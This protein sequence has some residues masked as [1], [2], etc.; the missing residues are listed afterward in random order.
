MVLLNLNEVLIK[1]LHCILKKDADINY[2]LNHGAWLRAINN[3]KKNIIN[4]SL[5]KI[6][7]LKNN[8]QGIKKFIKNSNFVDQTYDSNNIESYNRN[9]Y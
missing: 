1:E 7:S 5:F 3:E 2:T 8:N 6:I 9:T 4:Y